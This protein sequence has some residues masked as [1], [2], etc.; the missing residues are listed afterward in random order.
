VPSVFSTFC[1]A[2]STSVIVDT[3]P[4]IHETLEKWRWT[5]SPNPP[6]RTPFLFALSIK[7]VFGTYFRPPKEK[8]TQEVK[9]NSFLVF[10][11]ALNVESKVNDLSIT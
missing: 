6:P 1:R 9:E 4:H 2:L 7:T 5:K 10:I 3:P 11:L 8:Q